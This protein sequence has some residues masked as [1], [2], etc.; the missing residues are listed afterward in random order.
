M[1]GRRRQNRRY[2]LHEPPP[3]TAIACRGV[4]RV[5]PTGKGIPYTSHPR[6]TYAAATPQ[7][8]RPP[9]DPWDRPPSRNPPRP[10]SRAVNRLQ[11][12]HKPTAT[13]AGCVAPRTTAG[14]PSRRSTWWPSSRFPVSFTRRRR[15][16][17]ARRAPFTSARAAQRD[18]AG[19]T[20]A[21]RLS[22]GDK[23]CKK[24]N[25]QP[26]DDSRDPAVVHRNPR[27]HRSHRD[28][29]DRRV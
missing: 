29:I 16:T 7:R 23:A 20:P 6:P 5:D 27:S 2:K 4:V 18:A 21:T 28:Q 15:P 9:R 24:T 26:G 12:R 13:R 19:G 10:P 8:R 11:R 14:L 1:P 25:S 22:V 3:P 17:S